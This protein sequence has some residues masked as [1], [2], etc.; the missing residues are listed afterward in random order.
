MEGQH[1]KDA[2]KDNSSLEDINNYHSNCHSITVAVNSH[3]SSDT[4]TATNNKGYI[5]DKINLRQLKALVDDRGKVVIQVLHAF[6]ALL[7]PICKIYKNFKLQF[8]ITMTIRTS[9]AIA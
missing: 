2:L 8:K 5:Q 6:K 7:I 9:V 1:T 4:T 3:T